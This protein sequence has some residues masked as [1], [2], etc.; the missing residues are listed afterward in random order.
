MT[1]TRT[2][3]GLSQA[4][5][6]STASVSLSTSGAA[7]GNLVVL[8]VATSSATVGAVSV[9]GGRCV[10]LDGGTNWTQVGGPVTSNG[11]LGSDAI[12]HCTMWAGVL[13]ATSGTGSTTVTAQFA[14][15]T[16][17]F[18]QFDAE[19]FHSS[20]AGDVWTIDATGG[21]PAGGAAGNSNG[22]MSYP[23]LAPSSGTGL[24]V[25]YAITGGEGSSNGT[26]GANSGF[27]FT[28]DS[29]FVAVRGYNPNVTG[30]V[31]PTAHSSNNRKWAAIGAIFK[32]GPPPP[33]A[34]RMYLANASVPVVSPHLNWWEQT[35]GSVSGALL[36]SPAGSVATSS[37]V[38]TSTSNAFDVLLGQWVSPPL[39]EDFDLVGSCQIV[40]GHLES[41]SD[42]A[43]VSSIAIFVVNVEG[44]SPVLR[45]TAATG[46][47]TA[48]WPTATA[49]QAIN[50]ALTLVECQAGDRIVVELGYRATNADGTPYTGTI[51]YGG[52]GTTDLASGDTDMSRPSWID[53]PGGMVF[54]P[55]PEPPTVNAGS[56][57]TITLGAT[58]SRTA[59]EDNNGQSIT[60]R[61]WEIVSG[62][63]AGTIIGTAAALSWKPT[64]GDAYVLRYFATNTGG[65]GAD[66]VTVTV[67]DPAD[68]PAVSAGQDTSVT[69][70]GTFTRTATEDD[71]GSAITSRQWLLV[72]G[73]E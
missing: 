2:S 15:G 3:G 28:V 53:L 69:L 37:G 61:R 73:P 10:G 30:T 17:G 23:S 45:G 50:T 44:A 71:G 51:T 8:T 20:V 32:A 55:E 64:Q 16:P 12:T 19:Q 34:E 63:G 26:S 48:E 46:S 7:V 13:Q 31:A 35:S 29:G 4:S 56:D 27:T 47:T 5:G 24:Y 68:P 21:T 22:T 59:T 58:F 52:T 18:R 62:A 49:A 67:N 9:S 40:Q 1:I 11:T 33:T 42:A 60:A 6:T 57:A 25:G 38:E 39:A 43:L 41:D 65:T 72:S 54:G 66:D 70:G 14:N 36:A